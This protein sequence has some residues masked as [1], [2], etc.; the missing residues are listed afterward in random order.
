MTTLTL[1]LRS[2][3]FDVDITR[4]QKE[5]QLASEEW[6]L[7][8][9]DISFIEQTTKKQHGTCRTTAWTWTWSISVRATDATN[10]LHG[11]LSDATHPTCYSTSFEEISN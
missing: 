5:T 9:S 3:Y 2:G 7:N 8:V 4:V 11:L 10:V 1:I 6:Y